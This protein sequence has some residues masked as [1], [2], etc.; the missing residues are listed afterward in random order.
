MLTVIMLTVI[1]LCD[2]MLFFVMLFVAMLSVINAYCRYAECRYP[3]CRYAECGCT[4]LLP[5]LAYFTTFLSSS[6]IL[7]TVTSGRGNEGDT[8]SRLRK[9]PGVLKFCSKFCSIF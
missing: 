6:L 7:F 3:E 4:T 5:L 2:V 9:E 1:M 8:K